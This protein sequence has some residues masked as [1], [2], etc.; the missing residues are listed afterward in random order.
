[1]KAQSRCDIAFHVILVFNQFKSNKF[2]VSFAVGF[3]LSC[4]ILVREDGLLERDP[5]LPAYEELEMARVTIWV[6]YFSI[7]VFSR[8]ATP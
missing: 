5:A 8:Y 3:I 7:L 6:F 2:C 4:R 1:M